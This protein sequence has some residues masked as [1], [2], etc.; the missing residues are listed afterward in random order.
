MTKVSWHQFPTFPPIRLRQ[1]DSPQNDQMAK[2]NGFLPIC[3]MPKH[4]SNLS[5]LR[6]DRLVQHLQLL[7]Q[8]SNLHT[9]LQFFIDVKCKDE[10][11]TKNFADVLE[12]YFFMEFT[13]FSHPFLQIEQRHSENVQ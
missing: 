1:A 9:F 10:F 7:I 12:I 13:P 4:R 6:Y 11:D 3:S 2:L 5:V 8:K